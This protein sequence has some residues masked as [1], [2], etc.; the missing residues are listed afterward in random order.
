MGRGLTT[1]WSNSGTRA[2]VDLADFSHWVETCSVDNRSTVGSTCLIHMIIYFTLVSF[3]LL[4]P[5]ITL[6]TFLAVCYSCFCRE[7]ARLTP[8][9]FSHHLR[10]SLICTIVRHWR[11]K[12][13]LHGLSWATT[14]L[15]TPSNWSTITTD[16]ALASAA[17][18]KMAQTVPRFAERCVSVRADTSFWP[19]SG[20]FHW[21]LCRRSPCYSVPINIPFLLVVLIWLLRALFWLSRTSRLFRFVGSRALWSV[22]FRFRNRDHFR[23]YCFYRAK[24]KMGL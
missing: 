4:S 8:L 20:S 19:L 13:S 21:W 18:G 15:W 10:I 23:I 9:R 11:P 24:R 16:K 7:F 6:V 3:N 12:R 17:L 5:V 22:E 1:K 14:R 2:M